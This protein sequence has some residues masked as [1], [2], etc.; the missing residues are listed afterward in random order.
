MSGPFKENWKRLANRFPPNSSASAMDAKDILRVEDAAFFGGSGV[1]RVTEV[2]GPG[3]V[4][5]APGGQEARFDFVII[6]ASG[7][8]DVVLPEAPIVGKRYEIKDGA[9]DGCLV[10]VTKQIVPSGADSIEGIFTSFPLSNCYQS[11][12]LIYQGSGLWRLV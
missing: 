1:Y 4:G 3:T 6:T 12:S 2:S 8:Y 7:D 5:Y 9:G 10:G 11:W